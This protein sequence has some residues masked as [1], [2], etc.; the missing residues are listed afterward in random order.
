MPVENISIGRNLLQG[1]TDQKGYMV[2]KEVPIGEKKAVDLVARKGND[3]IAIE[4][5]TGKSDFE[6]NIRKAKE[7]EF[8]NIVVVNTNKPEKSRA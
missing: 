7:A 5:E 4:I 2:E 8:E 6:E 1:I 3:R